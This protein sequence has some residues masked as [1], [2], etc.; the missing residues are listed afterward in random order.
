VL[1]L[2]WEAWERPD[3]FAT[4]DKGETER[5]RDWLV[6]PPLIVVSESL[7]SDRDLPGWEVSVFRGES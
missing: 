1:E 2:V 4:G 7:A 6:P 3:R 5:W